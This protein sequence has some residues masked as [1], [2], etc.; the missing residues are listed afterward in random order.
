VYITLYVVGVLLCNVCVIAGEETPR[1]IV[2]MEVGS[3]EVTPSVSLV[4]QLAEEVN[5]VY[6]QVYSEL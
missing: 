6:S 3:K 5:V 2:F 1:Y 4:N